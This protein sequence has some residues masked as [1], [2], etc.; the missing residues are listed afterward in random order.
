MSSFLE[1]LIA[2]F[3]LMI[4]VPICLALSILTSLM[5]IPMLLGA[6]IN[7]ILWNVFALAPMKWVNSLKEFI[8]ACYVF[9][10]LWITMPI[11]VF[12]DEF[13]GVE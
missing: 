1:K 12:N 8:F 4:G 11:A 7:G 9:S 3:V 6:A 10:I 2:A 5:W 13:E